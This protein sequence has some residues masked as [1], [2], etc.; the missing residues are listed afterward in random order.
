MASH[1]DA[2]RVMDKAVKPLYSEL[3]D[4]QKKT[5]DQVFWGSMGM[6]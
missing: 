5:A 6:M 4:G 2:V 1:L 3:S